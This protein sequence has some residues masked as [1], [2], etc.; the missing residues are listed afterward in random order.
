MSKQMMKTYSKEFAALNPKDRAK[1]MNR[2]DYY[3]KDQVI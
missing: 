2:S 1:Q 3:C